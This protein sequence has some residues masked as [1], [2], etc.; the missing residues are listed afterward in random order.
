MVALLAL[1]APGLPVR[2]QDARTPTPAPT[3]AQEASGPADPVARLLAADASPDTR[4]QAAADLVRLPADNPGAAAGTA[5][6][7]A[8][9]TPADVSRAILGA[10]AREPQPAPRWLAPCTEL[11]RASDSPLAPD[12]I[13]ALGSFRTREAAAVLVE[14]V[15]DPRPSVLQDA[16]ARALARL[17]AR[18]DIPLDGW[19]DWLNRVLL[20]SD[21]QW[22]QQLL[23]NT[24]RKC[25]DLAASQRDTEKHL[26]DAWRQIHLLTPPEQRSAILSQLLTSQIPSL[27]DLGFDLVNRE[28]GESRPLGPGVAQAAITLLT[29]PDPLVR[30]AAATLLDR[31]A[32]PEAEMPV[33]TALE[34]ES[35]PRA[36]DALL[37]AAS[38]W[39]SAAMVKPVLRWLKVSPALRQ[40]AV[41][42]AWALLRANLLPDA[43]DRQ[44]VLDGVRAIDTAS[45]SAPACRILA[46]LGEEPDL[47]RLRTLLTS[48]DAVTRVTGADALALR[49]DQTDTLLAAAT[50]DAV[51][52]ESTARALRTHLHDARGY[53]AL[54]R[55]PAPSPQI[56]S[57]VLADYATLLPTEE[58]V[59][60]ARLA[61]DPAE[62]MHLLRPLTAPDRAIDPDEPDARTHAAQLAEGLVLLAR[63]AI[64]L[65]DPTEALNAL[66][67]VPDGADF[68]PAAS[69]DA[70]ADPPTDPPA[71]WPADQR[72]LD[73]LRVTC[74]LWL[75]RPDQAAAIGCD[76]GAYLDALEHAITEPHAGTIAERLRDRFP[77][78]D[79]ADL[80]RLNNLLGQLAKANPAEPAEGG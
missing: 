52:F 49:A 40:R 13:A 74:L 77:D 12:A 22:E 61:G 23:L 48:P 11:A 2:A 35:D 71:P 54:A 3:A 56:R 45:L 64:A 73:N 29:S 53:A 79:A 72:T 9:D 76:P 66:T 20:L 4:A 75:N 37:R 70:P 33:L 51:L 7:T 38:R 59:R 28:I 14:I 15:A 24:T 60:L 25:Q 65:N 17:S 78:L 6:L 62:A 50:A 55:L 34:R 41:A 18:D 5:L 57:R 1:A 36:A 67:L 32:P 80:D 27:R 16:A 39:P 44:A 21:R 8:P 46:T 68:P 19:H 31:L 30:A 26:A 43:A 63:T 69:T 47:A 42:G 58:I 10:I